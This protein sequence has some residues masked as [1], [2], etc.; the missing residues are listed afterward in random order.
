MKYFLIFSIIFSFKAVRF[1]A[2]RQIVE[3]LANTYFIVL[4]FS[5]F[6]ILTIR[7]IFFSLWV[8]REILF[9]FLISLYWIYFKTKSRLEY[10][11]I[12]FL[13]SINFLHVLQSLIGYRFEFFYYFLDSLWLPGTARQTLV[14]SPGQIGTFFTIWFGVYF[15]RLNV[16]IDEASTYAIINFA[17]SVLLISAGRRRFAVYF[18]I[19]AFFA[20][21]AKV[22]IYLIP[23]F[24]FF[25]FLSFSF[26]RRIKI[27]VFGVLV[28]ILVYP[29]LI[30]ILVEMFFGGQLILD[31]EDTIS[32]RLYWTWMIS[33]GYLLSDLVYVAPGE[34]GAFDG[35]A[36]KLAFFIGA[37]VSLIFVKNNIFAISIL[38]VAVAS[39]QYGSVFFMGWLYYVVLITLSNFS[40]TDSRSAHR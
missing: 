31:L 16:F 26:N 19:I 28:F 40:N 23:L 5:F 38:V 14:Y 35:Y 36:S 13:F 37:L 32:A 6:Y 30:N 29:F 20:S 12:Y 11:L 9:F 21:M 3:D 4:F 8:V 27:F 15:D 18:F 33:N 17:L 24:F 22:F 10:Y 25:M 39:F 2:R 1:Q 34:F 7:D